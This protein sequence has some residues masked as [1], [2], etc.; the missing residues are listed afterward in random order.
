MPLP[1]A[2]LRKPGLPAVKAT[3]VLVCHSFI[4]GR[5]R[6]RGVRDGIEQHEL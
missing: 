4:V 2:A 3:V 1:A 6:G 5:S